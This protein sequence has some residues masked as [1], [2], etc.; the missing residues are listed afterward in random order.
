MS[1]PESTNHQRFPGLLLL[2]QAAAAED[3]AEASFFTP[4]RFANPTTNATS[5]ATSVAPK[6]PKKR[7]QPGNPKSAFT[8]LP[9]KKRIKSSSPGKVS[10]NSQASPIMRASPRRR[11][12][13]GCQQPGQHL[14]WENIDECRQAMNAPSS[15]RMIPR[16]SSV[17]T[18][19][20]QAAGKRGAEATASEVQ[21]RSNREKILE[22]LKHKIEF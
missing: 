5:N 10:D 20:Q 11:R 3:H 16:A 13:H 6:R 17:G 14:V 9:P 15:F 12:L 21:A 8:A 22:D 1:T 4:P 2:V 19:P 7:Y 18:A